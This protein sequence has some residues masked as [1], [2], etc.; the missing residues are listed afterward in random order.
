MKTRIAG[1]SAALLLTT[2]VAIPQAQE[3]VWDRTFGHTGQDGAHG[4][5]ITSDGGIIS[6]GFWSPSP[7]TYTQ[8]Y[9]VKT[10]GEGN[11]AWTRTYGRAMNDYGSSVRQLPDV[12]FVIA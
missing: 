5:D 2:M 1:M 6:T 3:L 4:I 8:L 7:Y 9:L 12:V 10:D 11:L